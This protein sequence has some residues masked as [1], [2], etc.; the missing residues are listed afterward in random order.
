LAV[1]PLNFDDDNSIGWNSSSE[2]ARIMLTMYLFRMGAVLIL[3]FPTQL[4]VIAVTKA[5]K[6][7]YHDYE[8]HAKNL[9]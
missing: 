5:E 7:S 2:I 8:I 4:L 6:I 9:Y 3:I 1:V